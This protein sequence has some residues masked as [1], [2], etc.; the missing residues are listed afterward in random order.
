MKEMNVYTPCEHGAVK[1]QRTH[2]DWDALGLYEQVRYRTSFHPG[3][4]G[5]SG[6][7]ENDEDGFDGHVGDICCDPPVEGFRFLLEGDDGREKKRN[8]QDELVIAFFDISSAHFHSPVR[9]KVAIRVQGDPSCPSGI[10]MFNRAMYGTKDAAQSFDLY[11]EPAMDQLNCNIGVLNPCLYKHLVK[12]ISVP[13]HGDDFATHATRFQIAEFKKELSR[14]PLVKHIATLGPKPQ[15][16]ESSEVR[17]LNGVIRWIVPPFGTAS[18]RTEIEADPRHSEMLI[19][20]S[21]LQTNS[22]GVNTPR[23]RPR[24]SLRTIKLSPQDSASY[25]SNVMRLAYLSAD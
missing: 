7:E 20:N 19:K 4:T 3:Q 14:Y 5:C 12:D 10:A 8:P 23:E 13:R 21:G 11:C 17:F 24:D 6:D 2:T 16:L 15:L 18:E 22:K 9:R 25:R 1:E